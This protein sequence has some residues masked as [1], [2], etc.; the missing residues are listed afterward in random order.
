MLHHCQVFGACALKF[1]LCQR[2]FYVP[3]SNLDPALCLNLNA[4][5]E[6]DCKKSFR[7]GHSDIEKILVQLQL[8]D[9]I[10]MPQHKDHVLAVEGLCL[11]LWHLSYPCHWFNLQYQFGKHVSALSHVFYYVMHLRLQKVNHGLL[12]YNAS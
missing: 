9:V 6:E 2:I 11:V 12:F 7:F 4:L 3:H 8:L 10:I 5:N 1:L